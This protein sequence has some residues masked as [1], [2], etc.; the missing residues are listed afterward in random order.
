MS[1]VVRAIGTPFGRRRCELVPAGQ[2]CEVYGQPAVLVEVVELNL[3][4]E[5]SRDGRGSESPRVRIAAEF[6][7]GQQKPDADAGLGAG[8]QRELREDVGS[9]G[10]GDCDPDQPALCL[11]RRDL[12][13]HA[14]NRNLRGGRL[15]RGARR[16]PRDRLLMRLDL[17]VRGLDS[18]CVDD[19][20]E[21]QAGRKVKDLV[22]RIG[23]GRRLV[24]RGN[25]N[26]SDVDFHRGGWGWGGL[27]YPEKSTA[28]K[29]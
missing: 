7:A 18:A 26:Q 14:R 24:G 12:A 5:S 11:C 15:P 28:Q 17:G 29:P 9:T 2:F 20:A 4:E 23:A 22:G 1:P 25:W 3:A 6:E 19:R 21:L 16:E 27:W 10:A 8:D 13:L